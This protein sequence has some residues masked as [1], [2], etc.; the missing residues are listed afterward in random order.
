MLHF[1]RWKIFLILF[2]SFAAFVYSAP[3]VMPKS[4]LEG[5]PSWLPHKQV[6]LGLDLRGGS[7][8]LLEVDTDVALRD[9][10]QGITSDVRRVLRDE[11]IAYTGLGLNNGAVTAR[12]S[13]AADVE[14]AEAAIGKLATYV[15]GTSTTGIPQKDLLITAEGQ[16]IS[17][18]FSEAAKIARTQSAIDQSIEIVRRR[19]DELG[20]TEPQIQQQG[21]DRILVQVPGLQDPARLKALLGQTAKLNFQLVDTSIAPQ[22]AMASSVPAGS[23]IL[24]TTDKDP[25]PVLVERR[26]L[27]GGD[28]LVD[29]QPGFDSRT[30]EPVVNFHFDANGARRFGE[31]TTQNVNKPFAIV[32]D[33]KVVSAPMIR[34]PIMGGQG[35]ISGSFTIQTANDLAILLRA[36]AL[37]APLNILEERT[38]GPGLG[39]D[40]IRA[41]TMATIIGLVG[42]IVFM[43]V[44]YGFFGFL[45]NVALI[46]NI[47]MII[48]ILSLLQA[49]L[50]LPG[51]AGIV[52]TIGM[53]VDANVLIYERIREEV[54][55][56]KTPI[57]A[58]GAGYSRAF[59][60]IMDANIT[61]FISAAILFE[62]GSGPVRGFAVAHAIGILTSVFTSFTVNRLMVSTWLRW[63]RPKSINI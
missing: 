32:L 46:I 14:K 63:R 44:C 22:Q 17:V 28:S 60:T 23:Q 54:R 12:I 20:T 29:A 39:A 15:A 52:L 33:N 30:G 38:V 21:K 56:G 9:R 49:T 59:G 61:N 45:A 50:T 18:R 37:P 6:S 34:E 47:A 43:F 13:N 19:I 36:G 2:V 42:V 58:V 51:I 57:S 4:A 7:Y 11:Q 26:I 27:V 41:G 25:R 55:A 16:L 31:A 48:G 5:L 35:Q 62:V 3:N 10:L 8:L 53:A 40:S 24:Y 1:D